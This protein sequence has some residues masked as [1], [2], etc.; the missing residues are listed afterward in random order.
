[1]AL[2]W[3]EKLLMNAALIGASVELSEGESLGETFLTPTRIYVKPVLAALQGT[4]NSW[5]GSH[6]WWWIARKPARCLGAG[7]SFRLTSAA[8]LFRPSF[9]G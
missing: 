1:M 7:Q 5:H 2:V 9:S 3:Y 8:G 6:H 4:S